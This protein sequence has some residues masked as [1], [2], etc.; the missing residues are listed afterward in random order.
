VWRSTPGGDSQDVLD[1]GAPILFQAIGQV[2]LGAQTPLQRVVQVTSACSLL[3]VVT[4]ARGDRQLHWRGVCRCGHCVPACGTG[5]GCLTSARQRR[6]ELG[7]C[8]RL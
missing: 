6:D 5:E 3:I 7:N 8:K 1:F 4:V 2:H